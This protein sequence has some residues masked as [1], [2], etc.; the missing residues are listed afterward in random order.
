M[1]LG[2]H[3]MAGNEGSGLAAAQVNLF[4]GVKYALV[5]N[6]HDESKLDGR[7]A[8]FVA[9]IEA[10]RASPVWIDAANHDRATAFISHLP[11]L[12]AVAL[13]GVTHDATDQTGMPLTLAGRGLRD[14]LRL[15]GSPYPVWRD[16]VLTNSDNL[17][18]ALDRILE[19]LEHLRK[20]LRQ[21]ELEHEFAIANE[22]YAILRDL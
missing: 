4:E 8:D 21:R 12:V 7:V 15:A 6:P 20:H 2:G 18:A 19:A 17:D 5:R 13:A 14:A 22:V 1:F 10:M 11:Q 9:L 16:I 3:P